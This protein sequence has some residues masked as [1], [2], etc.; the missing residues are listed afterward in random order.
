MAVKFGGFLVVQATSHV[1]IPL[2]SSSA[3]TKPVFFVVFGISR[4][5][6]SFVSKLC[7]S[8]NTPGVRAVLP[9]RSQYIFVTLHYARSL[10]GLFLRL[11]GHAGERREGLS[12][13]RWSF[14]VGSDLQQRLAKGV[15]RKDSW[16]LLAD[17][18]GAEGEGGEGCFLGVSQGFGCGWGVLNLESWRLKVPHKLEALGVGK[19][20]VWTFCWS[21]FWFPKHNQQTFPKALVQELV[22]GSR[23]PIIP[24]A[25]WGDRASRLRM[26]GSASKR[27]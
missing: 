27:L 21:H 13:L 24:E 9:N 4:S 26:C 11:L 5:V 6:P 8:S 22:T 14:H 7:T 18:G 3:M 12:A 17:G 19:S 15:A 25:R 2:I 1:A 10:L 16:A 23:P 20:R